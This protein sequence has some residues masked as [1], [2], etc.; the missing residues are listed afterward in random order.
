MSP[1]WCFSKSPLIEVEGKSKGIVGYG[2][3]TARRGGFGMRLLSAKNC[4]ITPHM[5]WATAE[6]RSRL[7]AN[8]IENVKAFVHGAPQN[9]VI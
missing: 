1:D 3:S 4:L 5:A 2:A 9:M 8:V 6:A 7:M